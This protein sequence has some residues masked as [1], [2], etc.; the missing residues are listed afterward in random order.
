MCVCVCVC[1]RERERGRKPKNLVYKILN[2]DL[3]PK[4]LNFFIKNDNE[5][6]PIKGGGGTGCLYT[7]QQCTLFNELDPAPLYFF[8]TAVG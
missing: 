4:R 5:S 3:L 8:F 1:D 7:R 2:E 6:T